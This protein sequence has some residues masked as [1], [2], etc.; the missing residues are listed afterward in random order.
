MVFKIN[1]KNMFIQI[2]KYQDLANFNNNI[3]KDMI[4]K[5]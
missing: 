4:L 5:N 3:F 2:L 1:Q